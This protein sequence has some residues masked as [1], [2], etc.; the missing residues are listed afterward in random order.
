MNS[1]QMLR[2]RAGS[3]Y[4]PAGAAPDSGVATMNGN[5]VSASFSGSAGV[6]ADASVQIAGI[7][8]LVIMGILV[9]S[10]WVAR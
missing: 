2:F 7:M 8:V 6:G 5:G 9:A 1:V 10:H 4:T 3:T